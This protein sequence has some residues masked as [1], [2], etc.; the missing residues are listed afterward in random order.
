[1]VVDTLAPDVALGS[2]LLDLR[3]SM[4]YRRN[5]PINTRPASVQPPSQLACSAVRNR[6]AGGANDDVLVWW[7]CFYGGLL[8]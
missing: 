1:M 5:C 7:I 3:A 6:G 2:K 4:E 8:E